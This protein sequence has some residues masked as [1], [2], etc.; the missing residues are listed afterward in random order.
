MNRLFLLIESTWHARLALFAAL[1]ADVGT[2][3]VA[4]IESCL[5][6]GVLSCEGATAGGENC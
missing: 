1:D 3:L 5:P 4:D 6:Q 2:P